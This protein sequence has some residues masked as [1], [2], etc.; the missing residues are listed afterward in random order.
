VLRQYVLYPASLRRHYG[1]CQPRSVRKC[2]Q[3]CHAAELVLRSGVRSWYARGLCTTS[4]RLEATQA[5][6]NLDNAVW[7]AHST[8]LCWLQWLWA[9]EGLTKKSD[10]SSVSTVAVSCASEASELTVGDARPTTRWTSTTFVGRRDGPLSLHFRF[11]QTTSSVEIVHNFVADFSVRDRTASAPRLPVPVHVCPSQLSFLQLRSAPICACGGAAAARLVKLA[12][13]HLL[14]FGLS[15]T[16]LANSPYL[17]FGV[18]L[19]RR[20]PIQ[21]LF[22]RNSDAIQPEILIENSVHLRRS[23]NLANSK[24]KR[25]NF[26]NFV[27]A[28]FGQL[29]HIWPTSWSV[30]WFFADAPADGTA[31]ARPTRGRGAAH[32]V[33]GRVPS[34]CATETRSHANL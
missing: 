12:N 17:G 31:S 23:S 9:A 32:G 26:S 28:T 25:S 22:C 4:E 27:L 19:G 21:P 34:A 18:S 14:G 6:S 5:G 10:N 29:G 7:A 30:S 24:I 20:Q 11:Q 1:T 33:Q 3:C 13:S 2:L 15:L 16:K 8:K